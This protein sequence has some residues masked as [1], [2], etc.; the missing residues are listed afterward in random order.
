MSKVKKLSTV[1]SAFS[2]IAEKVNEVIDANPPITAGRFIKITK[3]FDKTLISS[4]I[5]SDSIS[6][7]SKTAFSHPFKVYLDGG[8]VTKAKI[9]SQ[10]RVYT[11][12]QTASTTITDLTTA[13][14]LASNTYVW[15]QF[16][17]SSLAVT[18][19]SRQTGTA[20]P[21]LI[22]TSGSPAVQTQFNVPIG[23]VTASAPTAPGFEFII[24]STAYHF[25]QCLFS[26]L[27]VENRASGITP[28]IYAF[29]WSGA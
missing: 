22:V 25:E 2:A 10:S 21:S 7:I 14:T 1:P 26:H 28:I 11:L 18:A 17:V 27:L 4:D 8:D 24:G 5:T 12:L 20:W 23:K 3:D 6:T 16:T 19:I 9:L 29:S 13:F 15:L